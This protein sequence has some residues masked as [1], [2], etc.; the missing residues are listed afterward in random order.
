VLIAY[1]LTANEI[2]VV[3]N[4]G[5]AHN[6]N[7]IVVPYPNVAV[8][9]GKNTL[10]LKFTAIVICANA[11]YQTFQSCRT[12]TNPDW[13]DRD[14]VSSP[15]LIPT[16]SSMRFWANRRSSGVRK[17]DVAG[18]SGRMKKVKRP[19]KS[20]SPPSM[21]KSHLMRGR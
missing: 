18:K 7:V 10:R 21:K 5:G 20:V 16:S 11:R 1:L 13:A 6:N 3:S 19:I 9:V 17:L 2:P 15:S 4:Q 14:S 8:S 12:A